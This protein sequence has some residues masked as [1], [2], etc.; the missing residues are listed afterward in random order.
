V[1]SVSKNLADNIVAL[2]KK[3][4]LSQEQ[5]AEKIG[6]T[7]QAVSN[8]E[9]RIATPD[10]ET[11]D[12]IAKLFDADLT[13]LVNGE[14]TAAEKPK[15]KMTFSK[16]EYLI[17]PCKVSS[18]PY[19][20]S[21]SI[22]VPDG[23]CIVH[24]D[25]FNKTEY[26]HYI[27]EPYFRLIHSLQD[28]SIQVL[29]QGYLLYNATLKDFAEHINSCY[30]GICVTEA[31]LRDYTARPVYDS[32]LWLA[33]KNNQTD[34]V[35]ATGIAE[36]DK[37]VGEGVLEWIQV[38]EQYRGYGLGKYVVSELLWRMKENATFATVSGQCN[39]PTNPE[40]L[41]RKCGFTG[42]DVWHVLRKR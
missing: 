4:G 17:C 18:I 14:S 19:W 5:F 38:S 36:L 12:L 37:E 15:D 35:V 40:A 8:W 21:K 39:N 7:R 28:L 42:S 34:E 2:R 11:L 29:P 22:T 25:N 10:V 26:Q 24:K 13:A 3:H 23:M 41:Y 6:V 30:S 33:I 9:C 16:N 27:D 31:D 32:S 1:F 20:K